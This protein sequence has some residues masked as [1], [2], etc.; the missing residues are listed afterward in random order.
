MGCAQRPPW[1]AGPTQVTA[2]PSRRLGGQDRRARLR[3]WGLAWLVFSVVCAQA[4]GLLHGVVHAGH[5]HALH[6]APNSAQVAAPA[7]RHAESQAQPQGIDALFA[8]HE[9]AQDCRLL[10]GLGQHA[11][12]LVLPVLPLAPASDCGAVQWGDGAF[13]VRWATLFDARAP[14]LSD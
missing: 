11:P 14:P 12:A 4:L 6:S 7:A 1:L 13:V 8:S 5:A 10:D 9:Q 2:L 3:R